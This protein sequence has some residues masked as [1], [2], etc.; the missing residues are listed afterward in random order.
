MAGIFWI[1]EAP[2]VARRVIAP[3]T[4]YGAG[5]LA[6]A[7]CL[8]AAYLHARSTAKRRAAVLAPRKAGARIPMIWY[9][10]AVAAAIAMLAFAAEPSLRLA[11][12]LGALSTLV[13]L[14]LT[15]LASSTPAV[16]FGDDLPVE[17]VVDDRARFARTSRLLTLAFM[18]PFVFCT[19]G[20]AGSSAPLGPVALIVT[21][22]I[23]ASYVIW[24]L[25]R[26]LA[27]I[28]MEDVAPVVVATQ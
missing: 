20:W 9:L 4:A 26:T 25:S 15:L 19:F 12:I 22:L 10:L 23:A 13:V 1:A 18:Q 28:R 11:A 8:A 7:A 2:L 16:L 14:G 3:G 6:F 5:C 24:L 21:L 17:Q 27:P